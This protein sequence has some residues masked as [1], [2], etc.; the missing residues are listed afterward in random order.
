M[1]V[2]D[3]VLPCL[4]EA[5]A[6]PWVLG[7]MPSW[8]RP[9]VADNGSVDGS[10]EV[11]RAHGARVVD[12]PMRGYGAACHAGLEAAT[13]DLVAFMDADSSLDPV[14]LA[15]LLTALESGADLVVG[16]RRP[17]GR[18]AWP[19]HLRLANAVV[20]HRLGRRTGLRLH[21]IGPMRLGRRADL[22]RV[23]ITDRRSGYPLETVVRVAEAGLRVVEVDVDYHPRTGRSKVTGT[24]LGAARA[25]RD[26]SRVLAR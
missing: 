16:R 21:D 24:P 5:Q 2:V 13:S 25:V 17:I 4:D 10:P 14:D 23:G 7:R 20:A 15:R 22:L 1:T 18:G 8:A 9:I 12:V 19:W 11:A 6:L 3:V 26:M